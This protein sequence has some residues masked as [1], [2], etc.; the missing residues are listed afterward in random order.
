MSQLRG[1]AI[2]YLGSRPLESFKPEHIRDWLSKLESAVPASSYRRVIYNSVSTVFNAAVDDSHLTKNPCRARSVRPPAPG[3]G[4]VIPWTADRTFAVRAA[5]PELY[6]ATVDLG[7]GCGL[8]QGEIFGLP[9]DEIK[10]DTGWLHIA[11]QVKVANGQLVFG[12][13]KRDKVRDVRCPIA[14][15][16]CS[17]GIGKGSPGGSH[18][19]VAAP[20]RAARHE[21]AV[22]HSPRWWGCGPAHRFQHSHVEAR[23]RCGRSHPGARSRASGTR[24]R[25]STV[26]TR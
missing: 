13:P 18:V 24:R 17:S 23:A 5:L 12:P 16:T 6:R 15:R 1:H 4:R 25:E 9:E 19:A 8:R 3:S 26:C 21:T 20:G 2:P 7:G 10:F 11:Y 22:V 14:S